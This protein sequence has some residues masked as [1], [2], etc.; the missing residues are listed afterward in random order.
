MPNDCQVIPLRLERAHEMFELPQ[1]DLFSDYRNFLTGVDY[2][3]SELRSRRLP[4]AVRVDIELPAWEATS[5]TR[6]RLERTLRRY[7]QHRMTYNDRERRAVRLDGLSSLR[8]GLP[9]A[10][11]GLLIA[12][13]GAKVLDTTGNTTVVLD[14]IGWVLAWVGLWFP[15]DTLLFTPLVYGR[16]NRVLRRLHDAEVAVRVH[17]SG[18]EATPR[19]V[20]PWRPPRAVGAMAARL[21]SPSRRRI[22]SPGRP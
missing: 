18:V 9:V 5:S 22:P 1:S 21:P 13:A 11:L 19:V 12:L 17:G 14:A 16:E 7:C 20:R 15:L 8:V 6:D 2:C 10:I 4:A 3:L